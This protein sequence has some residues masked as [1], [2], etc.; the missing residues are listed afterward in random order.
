SY[1]KDKIAE[2]VD[3]VTKKIHIHEDAKA[4]DDNLTSLN[5]VSKNKIITDQEHALEANIPQ[6]AVGKIVFTTTGFYLPIFE[7]ANQNTLSLGAGTTYYKDAAMGKG[8]YVLAGYNVNT[9]SVL[10][11]DVSD[12]SIGEEA[13]LVDSHYKYQYTMTKRGE[14]SDYVQLVNTPEKQSFLSLPKLGKKPLLTLL[15][16]KASDM[17]S[18]EVL[19]GELINVE[20]IH[21]GSE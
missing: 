16:F 15:T 9:S 10:F 19:Q 3:A 7:G 6:E 20:E 5:G 13:D 17:K 12:L 8:N 14:I 4:L 1:Q 11:S 18:C 21:K 2:R